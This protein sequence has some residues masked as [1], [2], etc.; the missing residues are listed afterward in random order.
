MKSRFVTTNIISFVLAFAACLVW[1]QVAL[2]GHSLGN[3]L[4]VLE[5][6]EEGLVGLA[7]H[8]LPA[9]VSISPFVPESSVGTPESLRKRPNN[10][11]AGVIIDGR[12]GYLITNAHVVR[13]AEK[14]RVTLY[15][16]R[17]LVGA[18][19][20]TDEETDLAVVQINSDKVLPQVSLGDSSNLKIGQLVVAIGNPYGLKETLSLGVISGLNRENINLSRYEDFIQT[21]ASINPGN[22]GGP[23]LNI[24]GEVIGINTAIINYAQSIGFAIPSNVVKN[25][26][27]QIIEHG[28]V[29]RGWLGVGIENV[30]DDV[31]AQINLNKGQG[32][33]I[34]SVFEGQPAHKAGLK[35]GDIILKIGGANVDSPNGMIRLI[36]NVS[37]GQFINLDILRDGKT[38]SLSIQLSQRKDQMEMASLQK[39]PLPELGFDWAD[40]ESGA[41]TGEREDS[42][43][44]KE[45][46]LVTRVEPGGSADRGGLMVGDLIT[47]LNGQDVV[48]RGHF[49]SILRQNYLRGSVSV[50]VQ[51]ADEEVSL[52][53]SRSE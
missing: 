16:G 14:I 31:A 22:S 20:G 15:G 13:K 30:P 34:N 9:V 12:N 5:E 28:E 45:G 4:R 18:V 32:V 43:K 11:G 36:G 1:N 29:N 8:T 27:H 44:E 26:S 39:N 2:A 50:T 7:E 17:E 10:A 35:V 48:N 40:H 52:T 3:G 42:S 6:V 25:V 37:P 24:R 41:A 49:E 46:V 23:L 38:Q 19:L 51:R 53:L 33:M 47:A 21:D